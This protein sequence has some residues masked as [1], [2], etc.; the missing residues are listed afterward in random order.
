M[1]LATNETSFKSS[2]GTEKA[3]TIDQFIESSF[4]KQIGLIQAKA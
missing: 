3:V 2:Y 4:K 1:S